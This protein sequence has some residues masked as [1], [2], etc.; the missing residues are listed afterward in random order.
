MR[1]AFNALGLNPG[2]NGGAESVFLNLVKGFTVY[3]Q[4]NELVFFCYPE[5]Q[6]RIKT[7]YPTADCVVVRHGDKDNLSR[8]Y[9]LKVQTFVFYKI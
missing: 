1:I 2:H 9:M 8:S 4:S 5:M 7:I 3:G 6:D